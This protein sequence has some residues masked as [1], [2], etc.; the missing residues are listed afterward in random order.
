M[1]EIKGPD[2]SWTGGRDCTCVTGRVQVPTTSM[3]LF[4]GRVMSK[5][6]TGQIDVDARVNEILRV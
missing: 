3:F 4:K 5:A 6:L 2:V 1:S